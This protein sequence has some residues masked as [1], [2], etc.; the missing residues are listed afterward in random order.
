MTALSDPTLFQAEGDAAAGIV[1]A[2]HWSEHLDVPANRD[3]VAAYKAK[4]GRSPTAY[5]ANQYDSIMLLD[6]GIRATGG[7]LD[8][9]KL[10]V[11]LRQAKFQSVRGTFRFN[12][13]QFPIQ[14]I[15]M[16]EIVK[17]AGGLETKFLGPAAADVGDIYAKDCRLTD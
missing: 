9:S 17:G 5:A 13:N 14:T 12:T 1:V 6:A 4:F 7:S 8:L 11:A 15:Y 10:R 2:T 16:E 3:F